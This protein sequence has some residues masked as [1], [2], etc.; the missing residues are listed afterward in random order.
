MVPKSI[1]L[2]IYYLR[3]KEKEITRKK[4]KLDFLTSR[5]GRRGL[6]ETRIQEDDEKEEEEE[7][8]WKV[9]LI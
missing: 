2:N 1:F 9:I 7:E 4:N 8:K 3:K 6:E 5:L